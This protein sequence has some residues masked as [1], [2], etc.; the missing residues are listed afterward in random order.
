MDSVRFL[1]SALPPLSSAAT[2]FTMKLSYNTIASP[3]YMPPYFRA[4]ECDN[5]D[6]RVRAART[7]KISDLR[8]SFHSLA[9]LFKGSEPILQETEAGESI[10]ASQPVP[11]SES[12]CVSQDD[13]DEASD[14]DDQIDTSEGTCLPEV[15][16]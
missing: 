2:H 1:T 12:I 11:T 8:T 4:C 14:S 3:D 13:F 5:L 15:S 16:L 10:Q 7:P 6:F 9:L